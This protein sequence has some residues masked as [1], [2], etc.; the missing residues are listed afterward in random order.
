MW[1]SYA[2]I[3]FIS[4]YYRTTGSISS[5][6]QGCGGTSD[7]GT[8]CKFFL[9]HSP[10]F[11]RVNSTDFSYSRFS[12]KQPEFWEQKLWH[13]QLYNAWRAEWTGTNSC[14]ASLAWTR[15]VDN[16]NNPKWYNFLSLWDPNH[17]VYIPDVT[18][19]MSL[20][21]FCFLSSFLHLNSKISEDCFPFLC[22]PYSLLRVLHVVDMQ[23]S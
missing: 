20:I 17:S 22:A 23:W 4:E 16:A 19:E 9:G 14:I 5:W 6:I 12:W 7:M 15:L 21:Q 18:S 11:S 2:W 3:F 13:L 10:S 1:P 8:H